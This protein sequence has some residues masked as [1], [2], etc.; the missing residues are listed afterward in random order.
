MAGLF[1]T[2]GKFQQRLYNGIPYLTKA[3]LIRTEFKAVEWYIKL[4]LLAETRRHSADQGLHLQ[5]DQS[6]WLPRRREA[7]A[8]GGGSVCLQVCKPNAALNNNM[9][10]NI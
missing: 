7:Q 3:F 4:S 9:Y 2:K 1:Y 5:C 6:G 10:T 8:A